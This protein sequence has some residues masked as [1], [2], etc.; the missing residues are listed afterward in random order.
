M[1]QRINLMNGF[2]NNKSDVKNHTNQSQDFEVKVKPMFGKTDVW[3]HISFNQNNIKITTLGPTPY[4]LKIGYHLYKNLSDIIDADELYDP[5][6]IY[7]YEE[8]IQTESTSNTISQT[9]STKSNKKPNSTELNMQV[10]YSY[11][12][13]MRLVDYHTKYGVCYNFTNGD[14][15]I[16]NSIHIE[17]DTTY[18][19][20][21]DIIECYELGPNLEMSYKFHEYN[22]KGL[23]NVKPEDYDYL[24]DYIHGSNKKVKS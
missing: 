22:A 24:Y 11:Q 2:V 10:D 12:C 15:K 9:D 17:C 7:P 14:K 13:Y 5:M 16:N 23:E 3:L 8:I 1:Y 4:W 18:A 20:E 21:C 19:I 6:L